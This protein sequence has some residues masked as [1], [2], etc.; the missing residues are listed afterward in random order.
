MD[1]VKRFSFITVALIVICGF[2]NLADGESDRGWIR[3][4]F[5]DKLTTIGIE[6]VEVTLVDASGGEF[7]RTRS[8]SSGEFLLY[9]IPPGTYDI[10]FQKPN[11]PQYRLYSVQVRTGCESTIRVQI[12]E[13][14]S[15]AHP[16]VILGWQQ[17][18]AD[19]WSCQL[20]RSDQIGINSL[21][22]ARNIWYL[23]QS[24]NP[25]SVTDHI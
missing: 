15:N 10:I 13:T 14:R 21:P 7:L 25:S 1:G 9:A 3:G 22:A 17:P 5:T 24:Q 2:C 19:L 8:S 18:T 11:L 20:N 16:T 12:E 23:L 6:N 4:T